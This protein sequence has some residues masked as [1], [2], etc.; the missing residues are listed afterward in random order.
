M[1]NSIR[2]VILFASIILGVIGKG[3]ALKA[4]SDDRLQNFYKAIFE[5]DSDEDRMT[6]SQE[7]K[8]HLKSLLY[9]PGAMER[10]FDSLKMCKKG[11]KDGRFRIFNW[12]IPMSD[13]AQVYEALIMIPDAKTDMVNVIELTDKS[14]AMS[15]VEGRVSLPN[16]WFGALYYDIIP[17]KKSGGD[18]YILLGWDGDSRITNKKVIEVMTLNGNNVRFG[19]PVFKTDKGTKKRVVFTFAEQVSMSMVYDE[20]NDRIIFDHLAPREPRLEGQFQFYGPD[21]SFDALQLKK[22]KWN[23]QSDVEFKRR[24]TDKDKNF[25]DP[26][27]K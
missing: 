25:N 23:W 17:F 18:Y 12:N 15:K 26:R 24:R 3:Q 6:A 8:T 13:G 22:G 16:N 2:F 19:A 9:E 20:K 14:T 11:S 27:V 1:R 5:Q 4:D 10:P 21:M 7:F